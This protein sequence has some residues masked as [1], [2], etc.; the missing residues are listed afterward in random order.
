MTRFNGV[1]VKVYQPRRRTRKLRRG[2][3]YF[4]GGGWVVGNAGKTDDVITPITWSD[5]K[6]FPGVF[7]RHVG[8]DLVL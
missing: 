2:L 3:V 6:W 1:E 4:H 8:C 7:L 5:S